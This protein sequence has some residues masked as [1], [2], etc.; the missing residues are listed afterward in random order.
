MLD[1]YSKY[2]YYM[3]IIITLHWKCG[4]AHLN[5]KHGVEKNLIVTMCEI[6][7]YSQMLR[8]VQL[9]VSLNKIYFE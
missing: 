3:M 8:I 6:I 4:M 1:N 9:P 2:K 7:Y 5:Q